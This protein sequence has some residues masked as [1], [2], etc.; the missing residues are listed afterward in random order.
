MESK[1]A[2]MPG[3][4]TTVLTGKKDD[5]TF[6]MWIEIDGSP[7]KVYGEAEMEGGGSEAWVASE[8]GKVCYL[9]LYL[10]S[11]HFL[12]NAAEIAD[13]IV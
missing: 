12:V 9:E 6:E 2:G 11:A 4:P 1:S 3:P 13:T 5:I 7:L 8:N 10:L